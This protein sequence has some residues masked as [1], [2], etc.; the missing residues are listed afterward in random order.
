MRNVKIVADSSA[1]LMGLKT[2]PFDVAPLKI[3]TAE[4]EFVDNRELDLEEMINFFKSYKGRSQTSCPNPEDWLTAFGDA[5]DVFC[6]TITSGLSGSYNA[7]CIAKDM[8]ESEHPGRRVFV[9]DSLSAGPELTLIVEK[10]E[11]LKMR[12][13]LTIANTG[14]DKNDFAYENV[15]NAL[16]NAINIVKQEIN[17]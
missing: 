7:A 2:V 12:Y 6:V 14:D 10:L 15:G 1:N 5:E 3:I 16:D 9:I 4:R 13:F 11:E 17:K 8:Y